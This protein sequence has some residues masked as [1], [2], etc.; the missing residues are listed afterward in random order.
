MQKNKV[1]QIIIII[2]FVI[3]VL[4][5]VYLIGKQSSTYSPEGYSQGTNS[6]EQERIDE[7]KYQ[8]AIK[9]AP[10]GSFKEEVFSFCGRITE[11]NQKEL[12]LDVI[13][14]SA[15]PIENPKIQKLTAK[16]TDTTEIVQQVEKSLEE[17][18]Q[19]QKT[20]QEI[21]SKEVSDL[22]LEM[23][24]ITPPE[25]LKEVSISFSEFKIGDEIFVVGEENIKNKTELSA[26]KIIL[27][28][29]PKM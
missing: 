12:S 11:I 7:E 29:F 16:L 1:I 24:L 10:P 22:I 8:E 20:K 6:Q 14:Y 18:I 9:N 17:Q 25:F 26:K 21:S 15:S 27:R 13:F 2:I 5:V 23:N 4:L 28:F 19:Y 3:L